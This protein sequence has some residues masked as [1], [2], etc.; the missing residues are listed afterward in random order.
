MLSPFIKKLMFARQFVMSDGKIEVLGRRQ[1]MLPL[2][3]LADLQKLNE[4]EAY[5][6]IKEDIRM[7]MVAFSQKIGSNS[8][9]MFK[10]IEDI[11]ECFGFG[12]PEIVVLDQSKKSVTVRFHDTPVRLVSEVVLPGALAG[13][14]SFLFGKKV[15]CTYK[16]CPVNGSG[17]CEFRIE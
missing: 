15:D 2:E 8:A 10:N 4:V 11:F 5:N 9:G 17:F 14:F 6:V 3:L 16:T 7:I 12:K 1:V 13:T